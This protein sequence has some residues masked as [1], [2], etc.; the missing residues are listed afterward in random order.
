VV[1]FSKTNA[2]TWAF[3][4]EKKLIK[5]ITDSTCDI[6]EKLINEYDIGLV[7]HIIIWGEDEFRNRLDLKPFEFY[8]R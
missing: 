5:I 6:P 4:E 7:P 2:L 8:Q 1:H 3:I